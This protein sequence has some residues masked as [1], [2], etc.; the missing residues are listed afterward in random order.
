MCVSVKIPF[1]YGIFY[2]AM[3]GLVGRK[4]DNIVGLSGDGFY[5]FRYFVHNDAERENFQ[6]YV[7]ILKEWL[8]Q[9]DIIFS[10]SRCEMTWWGHAKS[11]LVVISHPVIKK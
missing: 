10:G 11:L 2:H 7:A 6:N 1:H 5:E 3:I 9:Y 8:D 4:P